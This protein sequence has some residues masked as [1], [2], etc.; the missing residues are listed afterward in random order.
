M[1]NGW[2]YGTIS[3]DTG[4]LN[5][6]KGSKMA[7]KGDVVKVS[8]S[9]ID[10]VYQATGKVTAIQHDRIRNCQMVQVDGDWWLTINDLENSF[11]IIDPRDN[12]P[13]C[14]YCGMPA[15][16]FGFFDEPV[17]RGCGG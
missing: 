8:K 7:Q 4:T 12:R 9:V 1:T 14:H 16:S 17:C 15:A 3:I 11:E 5:Q 6:R 13:S 10:K 2:L